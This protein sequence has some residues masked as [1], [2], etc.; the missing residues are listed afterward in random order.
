ML[1][2]L[3][4][5]MIGVGLGLLIGSRLGLETSDTLYCF[6]ISVCAGLFSLT[7]TLQAE[8]VKWIRKAILNRSLKTW[9]FLLFL[10]FGPLLFFCPVLRDQKIFLVMAIPL[11]LATGFS[12][13]VFGPLQ[14]RLVRR[15][16]R[17]AAS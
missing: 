14:D 10:Y 15:A 3:I 7:A 8:Q 6:L 13:L 2:A 11:V 9:S 5:G 17:N 1:V 4:N 16:Q 12:I